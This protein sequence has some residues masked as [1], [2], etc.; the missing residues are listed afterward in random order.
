MTAFRVRGSAARGEVLAIFAA[1]QFVEHSFPD[2]DISIFSDC[3]AAV[4]KV[5]SLS[6]CSPPFEVLS[7]IH[8]CILGVTKRLS[9][10]GRKLRL[11][12]VKAHSS[13]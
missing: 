11:H 1:L 10:R 7:S 9:E 2:R 13:E 4:S 8:R 12:W 3:E 5:S 6:L